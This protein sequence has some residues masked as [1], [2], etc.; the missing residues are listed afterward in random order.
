[1]LMFIEP[2]DQPV[3]AESAGI[4]IA[5]AGLAWTE[6]RPLTGIY[7]KGRYNPMG[8]IGFF[9]NVYY[10]TLTKSKMT[11][12]LFGHVDFSSLSII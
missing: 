3:S 10:I 8:K 6:E 7:M 4:G 1:M 11:M 12:F 5:V 9:H 2:A